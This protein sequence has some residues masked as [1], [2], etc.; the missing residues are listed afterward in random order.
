MPKRFSQS[1]SPTQFFIV[2][3]RC[4]SAMQSVTS[5]HH[6]TL[7]ISFMSRSTLNAEIISILDG[8]LEILE[9]DFYLLSNRNSK[10]SARSA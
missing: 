6:A 1:Q 7:E 10:Q 4:Q 5:L 3:Q 9:E 2:E 8:V